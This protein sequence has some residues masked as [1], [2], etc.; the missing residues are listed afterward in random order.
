MADDDVKQRLAAILAA[1][2]AGYSRLMGED[3][4]ATVAALD[5]CRALFHEHVTAAGG[6]IVDTAGDSVLA[7][8]DVATGAVEAA[9]GVQ[10]ALMAR[11]DP[12]PEDRRM[13]FRIGIHLG[14]VLHK[15][16]GTIYGDGVNIAAR[17]EGLAEPGGICVSDMV[18]G[19]A[20]GRVAVSF[21]DL[22]EH[23][24]K[25]IAEPVRAYAVLAATASVGTA[26][27]R[28]PRRPWLVAAGIGVAGALAV[29]A[30]LWQA[31]ADQAEEAATGEPI[32]A[33]PTGPLVAVLPFEN[34][35]EDA[36]QDFFSDGLTEDIITALTRFTGIRVAAPASVFKYKGTE[37]DFAEI[38]REV[39]ADFVLQGSV[40]RAEDSI[41]V[42]VKLYDTANGDTVWG[43]N[44]DRDLTLD[45]VFA[46]QDEVTESVVAKV[47]DDFGAIAERSFQRTLS[48]DGASL[49]GYECVLKRNQFLRLATQDMHQEARECL[50]AAVEREPNYADAWGAL[51]D[52]Y[53]AI[54]GNGFEVAPGEDPLAMSEAAATQALTLDN[55]HQNALQALAFVYFFQGKLDKV[56]TFAD[57]AIVANPNNSYVY[58]LGMITAYGGE[59]EKGLAY[60]ERGMALNPDHPSYF[61]F[62]FAF[63]FYRR[64]EYDK[65]IAA[66][67]KMQL[68]DHYFVPA[69]YAVTYAAMGRME[70]AREYLDRLLQMNPGIAETVYGEYKAWFPAGDLADRALQDLKRAGLDIPELRDTTN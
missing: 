36:G 61:H 66:A 12:L 54:V 23:D 37:L 28:T 25:N 20:R 45:S 64:G 31:P 29:A 33:M 58:D 3:E 68:H 17:L 35:S 50:E 57:R 30:W 39:G 2:V 69:F 8:F 49:S 41:R 13:R 42:A 18:Q 59:W 22:G 44:F 70:E 26:K 7:V 55:D 5:D 67:E 34:R 65:A 53:L 24:V 63:D 14:E 27:R 32:A 19:A 1:D 48:R 62:P 4:R 15:A 9:Q 56:Q 38:R 10:D 40:R 21:D 6:R 47:G 11:N 46:I 60:L 43:E 16:D 51:A 52:I